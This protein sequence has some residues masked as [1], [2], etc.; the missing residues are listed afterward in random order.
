MK[1][2]FSQLSLI[3]VLLSDGSYINTD[4]IKYIEKDGWIKEEE[5][6]F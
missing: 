3:L 6:L 4:K 5:G 2:I 1:K